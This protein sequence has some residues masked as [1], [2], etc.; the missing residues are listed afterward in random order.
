VKH[1]SQ[2][3]A[4]IRSLKPLGQKDVVAMELLA[5]ATLHALKVLGAG[6][7]FHV[8]QRQTLA[9][10]QKLAREHEAESKALLAEQ[11]RLHIYERA[12]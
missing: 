6:T 12:A 5:Q 10:I 1:K 8:L 3:R 2:I 11:V 7:T 9:A 4:A